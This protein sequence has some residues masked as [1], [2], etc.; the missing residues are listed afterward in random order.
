MKPDA[1]GSLILSAWERELPRKDQDR[2]F[3]LG[4]IREGFR[5]TN[6][7][8]KPNN[9]YMT[10]YSSATGVARREIV[11]KQILDEIDNG[12]YVVGE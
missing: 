9:I 4:G 2:D 7:P 3:I 5:I 12:R 1:R 10:N 8:V 11:E 6:K